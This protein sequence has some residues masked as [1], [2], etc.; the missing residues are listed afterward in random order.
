MRGFFAALRM[1]RERVA[2]GIDMRLPRRYAPRND[3]KGRGILRYAQNDS[4]RAFRMTER[5]G[6][7]LR[8]AQN[9]MRGR[10]K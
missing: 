1:T 3:R 5:D 4:E 8:Y 7:I 9:D 2:A 6:G 10:S